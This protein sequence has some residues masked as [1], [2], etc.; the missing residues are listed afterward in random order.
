M[1]R[2]VKAPNLDDDGNDRPCHQIFRNIYRVYTETSTRVETTATERVTIVIR[3]SNERFVT[4]QNVV[5]RTIA[6]ANNYDYTEFRFILQVSKKLK[7]IYV[8]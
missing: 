4:I 8:M 2:G 7:L 6:I 5:L 3:N 1:Q